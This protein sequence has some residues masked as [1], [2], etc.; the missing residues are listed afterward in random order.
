MAKNSSAQR[1]HPRVHL[2]YESYSG[3]ARELPLV[4]GVV[5]DLSG[6]A[7]VGERLR[8][9][10]F[11]DVTED[12]FDQVF[13]RFGPTIACQVDNKLSDDKS[14]LAVQMTM[15]SIDDFR[16]E[17]IAKKVEPLHRLL[18]VRETLSQLRDRIRHDRELG[19]RLSTVLSE[20]LSK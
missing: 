16:P 11:V 5:A 17:A 2:R 9:R 12:S 7:S 20:E 8:D 10:P 13:A 18:Q 1:A 3:E 19:Q 6:R 4:V 15:S 14:S